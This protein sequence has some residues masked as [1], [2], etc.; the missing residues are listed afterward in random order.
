MSGRS[1]NSF[2]PKSFPL[3][4]GISIKDF[5]LEFDDPGDSLSKFSLNFGIGS[6]VIDGFNGF[7]INGIAI[8]FTLDK[9]TS[10]EHK[11]TVTVSGDGKIGAVPINITANMSSEPDDL[12]FTFTATGINISSLLNGFMSESRANS[13]LKFI[14][15]LFKSKQIDNLTAVFETDI[16]NGEKRLGINYQY[17][18]TLAIKGLQEQQQ[19]IQSQEKRI[20]ALEA[21][22]KLL[23]EKMN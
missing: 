3:N 17:F 20:S 21:Q 12:L 13:L 16:K 18:T 2:L 8:G 19:Q 9:P 10:P 15:D 14:P 11:A 23:L 6:Y 1:L 4:T 7:A 22:V 5:S